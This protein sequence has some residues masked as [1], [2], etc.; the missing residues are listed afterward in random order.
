MTQEKSGAPEIDEDSK[1]DEASKRREPRV[2]NVLP[3][4]VFGLDSSG[5]PFTDIAH[6]LDISKGG[7]RIG[8]LKYSVS[9]GEVIGVQ[10]GADKARFRV[11]WVGAPDTRCEQQAGLCCIQTDRCLWPMEA[12]AVSKEDHYVPPASVPK[13]AATMTAAPLPRRERRAS[14]RHTCNLG[15]ELQ[16]EESTAKLWA[17]CTD[18]SSGGCYLETRSPLAPDTSLRVQ[19]SNK[20]M[21]FNAWG[22]VRSSH[23]HFGMGIRFENLDSHT[24]G[25][26][27]MVLETLR[28]EET[29]TSNSIA[30]PRADLRK[31]TASLAED[32]RS[33]QGEL[34]A[35]EQSPAFTA[36]LTNA[37]KTI[38]DCMTTVQQLIDSPLREGPDLISQ[39]FLILRIRAATT[40]NLELCNETSAALPHDAAETRELLQAT[41]T[42]AGRLQTIFKQEPRD[43][44][45]AAGEI[46]P[47]AVPTLETA[48]EPGRH[49]M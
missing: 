21:T 6:T 2:R 40:I 8:G 47:R 26:L 43:I 16:V 20:A 28:E 37:F 23:P 27:D 46:R 22:V 15:A 9:V 24:R 31:R 33:L 38:C 7:A 49:T 17:R 48:T 45:T 18:L 39:Q 13:T 29:V 19:L 12:L 32:L 36:T 35:S 42:L 3:I 4:R 11:V 34:T 25:V 10:R 1:V 41:T 5:K 44:S 30:T 14:I